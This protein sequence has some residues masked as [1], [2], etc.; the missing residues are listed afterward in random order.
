MLI[1]N[2][3]R[4]PNLRYTAQNTA[5]CSF[6]LAT[7]RTW[8]GADGKEKQEQVEFHNIVAWAK[9]ADICG[10]LLHKGDKVYIEGRLQTRAWKGEDG[11]EKKTTEVIAENMLLLRTAS[12]QMA[13]KATSDDDDKDLMKKVEATKMPEEDFDVEDVSDDVPF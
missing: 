12:G 6:G 9:L 13:G 3:T 7:N 2:V 11:V 5:V 1:G 8:V 10:S 4:D